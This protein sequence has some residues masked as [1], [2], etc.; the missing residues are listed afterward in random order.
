VCREYAKGTIENG[1]D[2]H[3]RRSFLGTVAGGLTLTALAGHLV[4][5]RALHRG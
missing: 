4:I 5:F 1:F 3:S 2:R